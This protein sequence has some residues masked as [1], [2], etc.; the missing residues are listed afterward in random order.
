M[1]GRHQSP[2]ALNLKVYNQL[3]VANYYSVLDYITPCERLLFDL[4][5]KPEAAILD[6]GVG[7]GRTTP[8]LSRHASRYAGVDYAAEMIRM[9]RKKFPDLEFFEGDAS[10]LA[11]FESGSFD[12]VVIAFNG[13]DYVI[14]DE[15]RGRC[16]A[17]C[18]RVLKPGGV[19]LFSSHNPR[20]VFVRPTWNRKRVQTAADAL[21]GR[22]HSMVQ[23]AS[24]ALSLAAWT[25]ALL[26]A[27]CGSV[28]RGSARI[29]TRAFWRGEGYLLDSA[30]GGLVTHCWV[31]ARV[32]AEL[33]KH[34]FKIEKVLGDDYPQVS[35]EY[36][37][38][39]YYYVFSKS[40]SAGNGET[41]A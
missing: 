34:R 26:R 32:V 19:L 11:A 12:A 5:I 30:H 3:E 39:W 15:R 37:T 2:S 22:F 27:A 18:H 24:F 16:C 17:E 41:C 40:N 21:A 38:D 25:R 4:Y 13:F 20:S 1:S 36:T 31:P 14:P 6:L 33:Q 28:M 10:D 35:G 23:P 9:C 29:V 8:Y 7:A